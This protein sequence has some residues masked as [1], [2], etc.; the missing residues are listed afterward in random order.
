MKHLFLT[1]ILIFTLATSLPSLDKN[2]KVRVYI[3]GV[4]DS[5]FTDPAVADSVA[6][7]K[8]AF[9]KKHFELT[10]S[11]IEA[12][13]VVTVLRR[14]TGSEIIGSQTSINRGI[15]GGLYAMNTPI[16]ATWFYIFTTA[17][18]NDNISQDVYG[19]GKFW[20]QAAQ[21]AA[22]W[23]EKW[24]KTNKE[25]I[26]DVATKTYIGGGADEFSYTGGMVIPPVIRKEPK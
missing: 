16:V 5:G 8:K 7:L 23:Y 1:A 25:Q 22:R 14:T 6:D 3:T 18:V 12:H 13:M 20:R 21:G 17:T 26:R 9:S 24:I 10:N 4:S 15:F 19:Y 11:P 2:D